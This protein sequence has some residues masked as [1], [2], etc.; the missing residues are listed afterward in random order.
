[1]EKKNNVGAAVLG[2]VILTGTSKRHCKASWA[3]W[4]CSFYLVFPRLVPFMYIE[5]PV[6]RKCLVNNDR[7]PLFLNFLKQEKENASHLLCTISP[8][9]PDFRLRLLTTLYLH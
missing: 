6:Y 8:L 3:S 5:V 9:K 1:M 2:L 4:K 7:G